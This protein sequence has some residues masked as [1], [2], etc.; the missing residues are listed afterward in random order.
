LERVGNGNRSVGFVQLQAVE[1][2]SFADVRTII[3]NELN[4][5]LVAGWKFYVPPLG[6]ISSRQEVSLGRMVSFLQSV[7]ANGQLAN[8][9]AE[10]P[11]QLFIT[12]EHTR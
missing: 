4:S 3:E 6:P 2:L 10:S 12:N 11:L 1:S 8:G 5:E 7:Y 9:S